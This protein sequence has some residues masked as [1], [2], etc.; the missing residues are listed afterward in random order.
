MTKGAGSST[1]STATGSRGAVHG[2]GGSAGG[3]RLAGRRE[4]GA[5]HSG[6]SW[7]AGELYSGAAGESARTSTLTEAHQASV[8][9]RYGS[10]GR[11][12]HLYR[13]GADVARAE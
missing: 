2:T 13:S 4:P 5:R 11:P 12:E 3:T 7:S 9:L 10:T 1:V 8:S 6:L